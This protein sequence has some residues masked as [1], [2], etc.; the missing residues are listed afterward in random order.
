M[1]KKLDA[2][3]GLLQQIRND[4]RRQHPEWIQPNGRCPMCDSY[5]A[6]LLKLLHAPTSE[7]NGNSAAAMFC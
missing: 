1:A 5:E 6:R 3:K 7:P 4:L 2:Y